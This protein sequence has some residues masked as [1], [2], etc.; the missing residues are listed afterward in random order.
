MSWNAGTEPSGSNAYLCTAAGHRIELVCN[1][2]YVLGR[3][4]GCDLRTDDTGCSRRHARISV[5]G[6]GQIVWVED[7]ASKNGTFRN[8]EPVSGKTQLKSGDRLRIGG[9]EYTVRLPFGGAEVELDTHTR[10][11]GDGV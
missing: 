3:D 2:V 5:T 1:R 4:A 7:L 11:S 9:T 8:D 6:N 10:V